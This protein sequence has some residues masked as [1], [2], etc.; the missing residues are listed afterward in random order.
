MTLIG[1][2]APLDALVSQ[3]SNGH[4]RPFFTYKGERDPSFTANC[5]ALIAILSDP[6]RIPDMATYADTIASFICETWWNSDCTPG[7]K[8]VRAISQ[9]PF[10]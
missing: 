6:D 7:D 9:N 10:L 1:K 4:G 5:N 3:F 2:G 8:W